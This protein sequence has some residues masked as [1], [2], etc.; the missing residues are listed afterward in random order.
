MIYFKVFFLSV[1]Y[2]QGDN[3]MKRTHR[4]DEERIEVISNIQNIR[5]RE[6][7]TIKKACAKAGIS[8]VTYY[9]WKRKLG[10]RVPKVDK[11][12][13]KEEFGKK[14]LCAIPS[15]KINEED[16]ESILEIKASFPHMGVKQLRQHL[17][18]NHKIT[19]SDRQLRQFL[20]TQGVPK[21]RSAFPPQPLRR[22]ERDLPNEMWQ[23]DIMNFY[24]G[25][26]PL[27]LISFLDDYSR[28][29]VSFSVVEHQTSKEVLSLLRRATSFRK[30]LSILSDRGIQYC[31]WNGVTAFQ[32]ELQAQ[33][34]DHLLAR[35]QHPETTGKI[36]A[37]HKTIKRE[38]LTTTEFSCKQEAYERIHD[39][40]M[41]YNFSR[42]HMG[43][44][45]LAPAERY[46]KNLKPFN[47]RSVYFRQV[48]PDREKY[49][50]SIPNEKTTTEEK[51]ES[52][53]TTKNKGIGKEGEN[54]GKGKRIKNRRHFI[55]RRGQSH[56]IGG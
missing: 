13:K 42:P 48:A 16:Q 33:K 5:S 50:E 43:I 39:Y 28:F 44:N 7:I 6:G 45:N 20:E 31:S 41:F 38:L 55:H 23:T 22:F 30:P 24:V 21:L 15:T 14:P 17:I 35:E 9:D 36:E 2:Y 19:Y 37:F 54:S 47:H 4:T 29:I 34:I 46:F 12:T 8:D 26:E 11:P 25:S 1:F 49:R 18:R 3:Q 51:K 32:L 40:I 10:N 52:T 53:R 27:Y 56:F